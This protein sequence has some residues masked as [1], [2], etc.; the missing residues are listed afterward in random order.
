MTHDKE[1]E[2]I[3]RN[4]IKEGKLEE[5]RKVLGVSRNFMSEL[6][7]I[8]ATTYRNW[9]EQPGRGE[10]MWN[11]TAARV[12]TFFTEVH[13]ELAA[14]AEDGVELHELMPLYECAQRSASTQEYILSQYRSGTFKGMDL[15]VLGIWI[16][17][18]QRL[19][20]SAPS[21]ADAA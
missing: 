9:V 4:I 20:R 21:W 13:A 7:Y 3:G 14:L 1:K 15:G 6:L 18:D 5:L 12:A 17:R 16:F 11:K 19:W 8:S 10:K 2:K